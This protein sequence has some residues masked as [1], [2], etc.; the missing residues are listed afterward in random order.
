[1]HWKEKKIEEKL[2]KQKGWKETRFEEYRYITES[3]N[4]GR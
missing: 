1:V 2:L 4:D 3:E